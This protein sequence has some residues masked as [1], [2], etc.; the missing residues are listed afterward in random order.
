M[1]LFMKEFESKQEKYKPNKILLTRLNIRLFNGSVWLVCQILL[2]GHVLVLNQWIIYLQNFI[3]IHMPSPGFFLQLIQNS[4][5]HSERKFCTRRTTFSY[6]TKALNSQRLL[7]IYK[8]TSVVDSI[9]LSTT[10]K[11]LYQ[12]KS[13]FSHI[14]HGKLRNLFLISQTSFTC[15]L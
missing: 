15:Q 12:K 3:C 2:R 1:K 8:L 13:L 14:K 7:K 5:I 10:R 4:A 6:S 11:H 9:D